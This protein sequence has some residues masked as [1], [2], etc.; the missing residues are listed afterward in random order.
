[1]KNIFS[2]KGKGKAPKFNF[3][4]VLPIVKLRRGPMIRVTPGKR[5]AWFESNL[6]NIRKPI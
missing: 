4:D 1:M 2:L 6:G 3:A 5:H